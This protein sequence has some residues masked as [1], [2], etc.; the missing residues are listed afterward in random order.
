MIYKESK[1]K[2]TLTFE[3]TDSDVVRKTMR[4]MIHGHFTKNNGD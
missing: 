3:D 2:I 4:D 1:N